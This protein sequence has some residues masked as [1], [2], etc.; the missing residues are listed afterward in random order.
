MS[1]YHFILPPFF[2]LA[3]ILPHSLLAAD[4]AV[5][6]NKNNPVVSLKKSVVKKIFLGKKSFWDDGHKIDIYL[7]KEE[8]LHKEFT[9]S[10]L[11]KSIRQIKMYWRRQLYSGIGLPP[12]QFP[13][14]KT[15]KAEVAANPRAISYINQDNLDDRVKMIEIVDD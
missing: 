2:L 7:P 4:Y 6:V 12:Q 11:N 1:K 10:I 3:C 13:D 5:V 8:E 15:I 14:D 9:S